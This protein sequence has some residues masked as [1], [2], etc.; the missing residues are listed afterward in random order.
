MKRRHA[1]YTRPR[2]EGLAS[3]CL[4]RRALDVFFPLYFKRP[5]HASILVP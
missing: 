4:E 5:S 2:D 3:D 1:V